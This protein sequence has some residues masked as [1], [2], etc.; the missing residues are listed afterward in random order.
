MTAVA[1]IPARG[2][3]VRIP[4][5]N[6]K[7][8]HGRPIIA[9]SI[10]TAKASGLFER[11]V[12]STEDEEIAEV[13]QNYGA[14]AMIRPRSLCEEHVGTQEVT[15]HTLRLMA[16]VDYACCIY[17]TAPMLDA[18]DLHYGFRRLHRNYSDSFAYV[19]GWYYWGT[20]EAFIED[21]PLEQALRLTSLRAIDINTMYDWECAEKVYGALN[22]AA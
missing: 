4:R 13:A 11:V 17:A 8:F 1:I 21:R 3:S 5:K 19:E 16:P 10:E 7:P 2:G 20:R 14:D 18:S 15:A 6:I 22:A 9:Y 12:V